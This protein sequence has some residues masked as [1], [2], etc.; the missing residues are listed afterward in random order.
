MSNDEI[1]ITIDGEQRPLMTAEEAVELLKPLMPR[2]ALGRLG[3]AV[4][5]AAHHG[6]GTCALQVEV[7]QR[8]W[9]VK[10]S[11]GNTESYRW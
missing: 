5:R 3:K 9:T 1:G 8:L 10:G 11:N 2:H 7:K 4:A 6:D